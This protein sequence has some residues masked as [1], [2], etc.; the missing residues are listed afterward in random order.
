MTRARVLAPEALAD[1]LARRRS[2]SP[3]AAFSEPFNTFTRVLEKLVQSDAMPATW[4]ALSKRER[5][6]NGALRDSASVAYCYRKQARSLGIHVDSLVSWELRFAVEI[7]QCTEPPLDVDT[8][9]LVERGEKLTRMAD[10]AESLARELDGVSDPSELTSALGVA[11]MRS[12]A[13]YAEKNGI[14]GDERAKLFNLG[15]EISRAASD[16]PYAPPASF[17]L[18]S[19]A[20][21]WRFRALHG[22]VV[23]AAR[24]TAK[25]ANPNA[26]AFIRNLWLVMIRWFESPLY[27]HMC[28]ITQALYDGA[29]ELDEQRVRKLCNFP[30]QGLSYRMGDPLPEPAHKRRKRKDL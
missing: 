9:P 21:I 6:E 14:D 17:V 22:P 23:H 24:V 2:C 11:W 29:E 12:A 20:R 4:R 26:V 7:W 1:E 16:S 8:L 25:G 3:G 13:E 10:S 15:H 18:E 5:Y 28:S 27:T 19:L 30:D